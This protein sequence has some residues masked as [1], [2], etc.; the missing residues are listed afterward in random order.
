M[1]IHNNNSLLEDL[2]GPKVQASRLSNGRARKVAGHAQSVERNTITVL[3]LVRRKG[4]EN[5]SGI[6]I[7]PM[8]D[9]A[10]PIFEG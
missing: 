7:A 3:N 1:P 5:L 2:S 8:S 4:S 10:M 6:E 9:K